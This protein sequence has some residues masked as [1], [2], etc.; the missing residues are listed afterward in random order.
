MSLNSNEFID[1]YKLS[2]RYNKTYIKHHTWFHLPVIF[3]KFEIDND[4]RSN[5]IHEDLVNNA[6][7]LKVLNE[8]NPELNESTRELKDV[9]GTNTING[10]IYYIDRIEYCKEI[11]NYII[12]NKIVNLIIFKSRL[13]NELL[14]IYS[15]LS[16]NTLIQIQEVIENN[17]IAKN[18]IFVKYKK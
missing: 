6:Q 9:L 1:N 4:S 10:S 12:D 7:Y 11:D 5:V 14:E 2:E 15:T 3:Q 18:A 16:I 17:I 8:L 13:S